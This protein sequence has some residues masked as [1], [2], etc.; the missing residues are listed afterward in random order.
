MNNR[1]YI[2]G[3][4]TPRG[5]RKETKNAAIEYLLNCNDFHAAKYHL[6]GKG[7]APFNPAEDSVVFLRLQPGEI[8]SED[9]IKAV[10]MAWLEVSD[11]MVLLPGWENSPGAQAE[12]QRAI[13]LGISQIY[14]GLD[15]VPY[16]PE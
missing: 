7:W 3:A 5:N 9:T 1:I 8:I 10:S 13:E 6:I 2:A 15:E 12:H 14:Y 16:A 4:M 11:A